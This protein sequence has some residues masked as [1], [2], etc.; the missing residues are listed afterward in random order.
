MPED[1]TEITEAE[2]VES[3]ALSLLESSVVLVDGSVQVEPK[4]VEAAKSTMSCMTK[5]SIKFING[6]RKIRLSD[7]HKKA[8]RKQFLMALVKCHGVISDA[9]KASGVSRR[10]VYS[11]I[12]IDEEFNQALSLIQIES[13][14]F[15]E[16]KLFENIGRGY[17]AS[18]IFFLKTRGKGR[19]YDE[20]STGKAKSRMEEAISDHTDDELQQQIGA[21]EAKI[22]AADGRKEEAV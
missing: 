18:I 16:S 13:V 12:D 8:R 20:N 1:N 9:C 5:E 14:D 2:V 17:E 10:T 15:A 6:K 4:I 22:H 3:R 11:W 19:G 7:I 21:L